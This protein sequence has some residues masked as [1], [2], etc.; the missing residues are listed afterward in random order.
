V[1]CWLIENGKEAC[2]ALPGF[3]PTLIGGQQDDIQFC[4]HRSASISLSPASCFSALIQMLLDFVG[5]WPAQTSVVVAYQGTN[6]KEMYVALIL[7]P[8]PTH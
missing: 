4:K 2:N 7:N 8:A 6:P 1:P 5:Y 3:L